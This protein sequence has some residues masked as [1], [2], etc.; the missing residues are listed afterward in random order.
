MIIQQNSL[1]ISALQH[2]AYCPRQCALIHL[3]RQW[4]ESS[5]T[6]LGR[7]EHERVH[8]GYREFRRG[9]RQITGLRV[10]SK[11]L[12]LHGQLDVLEMAQADAAAPSNLPGLKLKGHWQ[13]YPVEFKHG[14]PKKNACDRIQLC[15]QALCLEEMLE[16]HIEQASLFYQ[17][18]RRREDVFIDETLRQLTRQTIQSLHRL[19][20]SGVTPPPVNDKRCKAC[21]LKS[22]CMPGALSRSTRYR[23]RLFTPQ[24]AS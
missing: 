4:E 3:E 7:L 13:L 8:E 24:E 1:P 20:E 5:H 15:A 10:T 14:Q 23:Q 19:F 16:T 11:A 2:M 12:G 22:L 18:I 21:S 9:R 6:A 17:R